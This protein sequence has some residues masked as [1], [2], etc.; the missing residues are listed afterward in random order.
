M[1]KTSSDNGSSLC[2][3]QSSVWGS[4]ERRRVLRASESKSSEYTG[5]H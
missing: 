2:R 3:G 1:E 4:V 5:A